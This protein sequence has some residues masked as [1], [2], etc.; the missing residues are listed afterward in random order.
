M[1]DPVGAA[2]HAREHLAPGGTVLLVEPFALDG[3]PRNIAEN[4]VAAMMYVASSSI[5]TPNSLSQEV[6]LALGAQAGESRL[7][8][9]FEDAGFTHFRRVAQTPMNLIIEARV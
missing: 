6:G 7:R 5:C 9:V 2:R 4:P 3:R 1:G 8:K